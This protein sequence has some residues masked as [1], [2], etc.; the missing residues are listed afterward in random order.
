MSKNSIELC[1]SVDAVVRHEGF[2]SLEMR[3]LNHDGELF[4]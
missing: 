3:I 1:L 2:N 4:D